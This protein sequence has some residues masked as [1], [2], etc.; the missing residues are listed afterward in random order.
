MSK[1][2]RADHPEVIAAEFDRMAEKCRAMARSN[3][4]RKM[5]Q[6]ANAEA[7]GWA[8]AARMIRETEFV[9]WDHSKA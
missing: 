8:A 3:K 7:N 6:I 5:Q 1:M 9:G 2:Y 4:V